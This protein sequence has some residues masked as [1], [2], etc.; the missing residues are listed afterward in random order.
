MKERAYLIGGRLEIKS[1]PGE[2]TEVHLL[3]PLTDGGV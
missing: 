3:I 2:G 1:R